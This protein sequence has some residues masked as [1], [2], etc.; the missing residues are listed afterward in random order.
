L[1]AFSLSLIEHLQRPEDHVK[2]LHR[3]LRKGGRLILQLPNLQYFFEPHT[4]WPLLWFMPKTIQRIIF[5]KLKYAYVNMNVTVKY[6][7]NLLITEGFS[8]ESGRKLYHLRAMK[9]I[10]FSPSYLFILRKVAT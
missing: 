2:E 5:E 4:K 9:L 10:P 3:V 8:L 1:T 7:L 6:A